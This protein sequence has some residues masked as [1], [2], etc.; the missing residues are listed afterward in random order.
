MP[1][2]VDENWNIVLPKGETFGLVARNYGTRKPKETDKATLVACTKDGAEVL[3]IKGKVAEDAYVF[4]FASDATAGMDEGVYLWDIILE[5]RED[6]K[7]S[8]ARR[9]VFAPHLRKLVI[10]KVADNGSVW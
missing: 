5:L 2:M 4:A 3:R 6:D 10:G 1:G 7:E 8:T 9:T